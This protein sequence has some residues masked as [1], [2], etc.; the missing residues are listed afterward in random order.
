LIG[1]KIGSNTFIGKHVSFDV[2]RPDLVVIG[3]NVG[4][5][6][7]VVFLTHRRDVSLYHKDKGYN[8]YPF[9]FGKVLVRDNAQIGTG[10]IIMPGVTIG[11]G[12][13]I[14]AGSVV[15][16]NVPDYCVA[17]GV[18]AKVIKELDQ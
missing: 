13:I 1:F 7:N 4:I 2:S 12:S 17:V 18:P 11:R 5:A 14:G 9:I 16:K 10:S 6:L 8:D 3:N 15:T